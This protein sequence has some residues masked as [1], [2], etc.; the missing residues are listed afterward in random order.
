VIVPSY[1]FVA[2]VNAVLAC[3]ARPVFADID[4]YTFNLDLHSVAKKVTEKTKAIVLVHQFGMPAD[5]GA[6]RE[7]CGKQGLVLV[8]DAACGLG[9][10]FAGKALGSFGV[11]GL[12]SFHPRKILSTGEG[13]MVL[14]DDEGLASRARLYGNHG[15][16]TGSTNPYAEKVGHN[17]RMSEFQAALGIWA[18][19]HL[20]DAKARRAR[21][22]SRYDKAF[23]HLA[24]IR[25]ITPP[26]RAEWNHQSYPVRILDGRRNV[27]AEELRK[28]GIETSGGPLPAHTHPFIVHLLRPPRLPETEAAYEET[29]LLP[30]Y[31]ALTAEDQDYVIDALRKALM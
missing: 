24:G 11:A 19:E 15:R 30:M 2:T 6:F 17:H 28:R 4:R 14:T 5:A 13:G 23:T 12:L 25:T 27:V 16:P 22:A 1:T 20:S 8:E 31:A 3:G 29:L 26:V 18:L 9:S 7:L 10:Q 21:V